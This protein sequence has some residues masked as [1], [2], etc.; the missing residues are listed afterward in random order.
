MWGT[1]Q[2]CLQFCVQLYVD[3][4]AK[5]SKY[6]RLL[7]IILYADDYIILLLAPTVTKLEKLLKIYETVFRIIFSLYFYFFYK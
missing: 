1:A 2:S 6:D 5:C 7:Y 3:N 4:V